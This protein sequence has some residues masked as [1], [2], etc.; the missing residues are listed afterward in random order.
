MLKSKVT[1]SL[2]LT[3]G[4][5]LTGCG[6]GG[7]STDNN[8][9]NNLIS[10]G[11]NRLPIVDAGYDRKV[12]INTTITI[13]GSAKDIDGV[14][15]SYEWKKGKEVLGTTKELTYTPTIL[16]KD[17]LT[18]TAIDNDGGVASDSIELEIVSEVVYEDPLP[19]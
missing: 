3:V 13:Y 19:F 5:L 14:I 9:T 12:Q 1:K 16:G 10:E 2:F 11:E 17:I 15:S 18:L 4:L 7:S 8:G 6:G